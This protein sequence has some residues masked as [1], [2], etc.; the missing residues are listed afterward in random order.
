MKAREQ[1]VRQRGYCLMRVA[2]NTERSQGWPPTVCKQG[3]SPE[4]MCCES[5]GGCHSNVR[6][7]AL[8]FIYFRFKLSTKP[9]HLS[10]AVQVMC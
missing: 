10:T 2:V 6:W 5:R 3:W 9:E 1:L 4:E 8:E 7:S